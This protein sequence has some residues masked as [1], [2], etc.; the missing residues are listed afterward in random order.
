VQLKRMAQLQDQVDEVR[1]QVGLL[2]V[3]P[4]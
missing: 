2:T 3:T 4:E 1:Q